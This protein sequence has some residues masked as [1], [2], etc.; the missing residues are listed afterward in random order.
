[1]Q[2]ALGYFAEA[3][4]LAATDERTHAAFVEVAIARLA[5]EAAKRLEQERR[6]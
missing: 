1:L 5:T 3:L 6:P 4:R 2:Q